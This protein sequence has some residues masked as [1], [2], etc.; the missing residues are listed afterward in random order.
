[1]Y[2]KDIFKECDI[3]LVQEH[4]LYHSQL[5]VFKT[6]IECEVHGTSSMKADQLLMGRPYGGTAI[7]WKPELA[8]NITPIKLTSNRACGIIIKMGHKKLL[9]FNVYTPNDNASDSKE[10]YE[11][12]LSKIASCCSSIDN[13]GA[14][15]GGDFN[16]DFCRT[17]SNNSRHLVEYLDM[18]GS[19]IPTPYPLGEYTFESKID[20]HKSWIDHF[21]ISENLKSCVSQFYV[22][23]DRDNTSD[24]QPLLMSLKMDF[25]VVRSATNGHKYE[26]IMWDR[27]SIDNINKYK[28][29][30]ETYLS[31]QHVPHN[32]LHCD[33]LLCDSLVHQKQ[34][35]TLYDNIIKCCLKAGKK[36]IPVHPAK[37]VAS[38]NKQIP[39]WNRY[40]REHREKAIFW[41]QST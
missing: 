23:H 27:A 13:D 35:E 31:A 25:Q 41:H 16:A 22:R 3:L 40:V 36:N 14:V 18:N 39:G 12:I 5:H 26:R 38:T 8:N 10:P 32:L 4:W 17:N 37:K 1:M 7:L 15:V 30:L 6:K 9:L 24:H 34:I 19:C 2:I 28:C 20:F 11:E 33:K 21:I 29:D